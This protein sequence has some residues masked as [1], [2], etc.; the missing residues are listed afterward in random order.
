MEHPLLK[1][2]KF[3]AQNRLA[4]WQQIEKFPQKKPPFNPKTVHGTPTSLVLK[5]SSSKPNPR[6]WQ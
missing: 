5:I 6:H 2:P 4:E 3:P 1:L